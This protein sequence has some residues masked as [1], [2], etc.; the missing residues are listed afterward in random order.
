MR[1]DIRKV[2]NYASQK[3]DIKSIKTIFSPYLGPRY[4]GPGADIESP[5]FC[6]QTHGP[7]ESAV[8]QFAAAELK[9]MLVVF[10]SALW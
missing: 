5:H 8:R 10:P 7:A 2:Y 1:R 6:A 9:K 4:G 3:K